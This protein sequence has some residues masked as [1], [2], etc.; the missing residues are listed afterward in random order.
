MVKNGDFRF[1]IIQVLSH[2]FVSGQ[3]LEIHGETT[4]LLDWKTCLKGLST[5]RR[6]CIR[7]TENK[8]FAIGNPQFLPFSKAIP[9]GLSV[10]YTEIILLGHQKVAKGKKHEF[11][12]SDSIVFVS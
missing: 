2:T 5:P 7:T 6:F 1:Q 4:V 9:Q 8:E 11:F 10:H 12:R 3:K